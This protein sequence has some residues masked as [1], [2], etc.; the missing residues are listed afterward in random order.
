MSKPY[1]NASSGVGL[2]VVVTLPVPVVERIEAQAKARGE[3][4][5]GWCRAWLVLLV[6]G[7]A[8]AAAPVV[9]ARRTGAM[10]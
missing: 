6:E 3:T 10:T 7:Q 1:R 9:H 8:G 4:V 2:D 5:A